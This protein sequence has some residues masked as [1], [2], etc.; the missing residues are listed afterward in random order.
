[1]PV[2]V[3]LRKDQ[4]MGLTTGRIKYHIQLPPIYDRT[5]VFGKKCEPIGTSKFGCFKEYATSA[6]VCS[7]PYYKQA[8]MK[9]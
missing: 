6:G 2:D 7:I 5:D 3:D 4:L 8:D 1:M 9:M